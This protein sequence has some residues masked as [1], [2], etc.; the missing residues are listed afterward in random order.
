MFRFRRPFWKHVRELQQSAYGV[1]LVM[2]L[3]YSLQ[4]GISL[5]YV[6]ISYKL[7]NSSPLPLT[8]NPT[9]FP[10]V[11]KYFWTIFVW[12]VTVK[13]S[14]CTSPKFNS[15]LRIWSCRFMLRRLP[16]VKGFMCVRR[17]NEWRNMGLGLIK[18]EDVLFTL[19]SPFYLILFQ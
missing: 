8:T 7:M 19:M 14:K 16:R 6:R 17:G 1:V 18:G 13:T 3:W 5:R 11:T 9:P 4:L 15:E 10:L 2:L 12:S